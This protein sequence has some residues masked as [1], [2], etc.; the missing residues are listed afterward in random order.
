[1]EPGHCPAGSKY[2]KL[3]FLLF[4]I[5]NSENPT[6]L[7]R[8]CYKRAILDIRKPSIFTKFAHLK[9]YTAKSVYKNK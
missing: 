2:E 6:I 4:S 9:D 8:I 5:K 7:Y 1:M 3:S